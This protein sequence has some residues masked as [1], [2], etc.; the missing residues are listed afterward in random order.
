MGRLVILSERDVRKFLSEKGVVPHEYYTDLDMF[1]KRLVGFKDVCLVV[2]FTGCSSFVKKQL[3]Q[4]LEEILFSQK[5]LPTKMLE[6]V[7][8]LSDAVIPTCSS[9]YKYEGAPLNFVE[10]GGW[11][12]VSDKGID[13]WGSLDTMAIS[14]ES[15]YLKAT[16][17]SNSDDYEKEDF[18]SYIVV[19]KLD[20]ID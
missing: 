3:V 8:I 16:K 19:P 5:D 15:I 2:L 6:K 18:R 9:Y 14:T 20:K 10:Y 12:K 11:D 17:E 1:K 13:V 7:V 4:Y